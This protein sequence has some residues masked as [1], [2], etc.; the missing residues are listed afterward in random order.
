VRS[1]AYLCGLAWL[2]LSCASALPTPEELDATL[3]RGVAAARAHHAAGR[4]AEAMILLG[5]VQRVDPAYPPAQALKAKIVSP[6][7]GW[8][9]RP[10][11]GSNVARRPS[12]ERPLF[13]RILLYLPD[14][15][16][17]LLDVVSFDLHFGWGAHAN[18]HLTRALQ[19]GAG[20]R[21]VSGIGWHDHRSL[22]AK[23]QGSSELT[24]LALGGLAWS[25]ELVGTSGV[26][27][28]RDG[29]AGLHD[30]G[31]RLYQEMRDYY[32]VGLELTVAILGVEVDLHPVDLADFLVGWGG[33]D[34]QRD[35]FATT[36][37]LDLHQ[38]DEALLR[39]LGSLQPR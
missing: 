31:D 16:L 21:T 33:L 34:I 5:A 24:V 4:D 9:D 38:A 26:R 15:M 29:I 3:D 14:R 23:M 6:S 1:F 32:A 11:L 39:L 27:A 30:P 28:S 10:R 37:G 35:D 8:S 36:R 13:A 20:M 25:G 17:D 19:A 2:G 22:G 12:V 18:L 7:I